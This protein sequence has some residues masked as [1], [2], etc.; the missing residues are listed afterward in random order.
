MLHCKRL[1]NGLPYTAISYSNAIATILEL[2]TSA[3]KKT[4]LIVL[5]PNAHHYYLYSKNP[6]FHNIY[7][8][9]DIS[10]LDGMPLVWASKFINKTP[11]EKVSGSDIFIS[12]FKKAVLLNYKI[13]LLGAAPGVAQKAIARLGAT[14]K[15]GSLVFFDSPPVG[16]ENDKDKNETVLNKINRVKPNILFAA[17]G[18]PKQEFWLNTNSRRLNAAVAI[19]VGGSFDFV[20]GTTTRAPLWM[21]RCSLEWLFRLIKEPRRLWKRYF[22]TNTFFIQDLIRIVIKRSQDR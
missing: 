21:Q 8:R 18:T 2:A 1:G 17:L 11:V 9:A 14:D 16:F 5:T 19:G 7:E 10:L 13:Y 22:I 12:L 3:D 15:V 6:E 4:P 20:A